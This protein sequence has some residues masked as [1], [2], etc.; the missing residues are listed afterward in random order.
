LRIVVSFS[1]IAPIRSCH[2]ISMQ[3]ECSSK[4]SG[5]YCI[6]LSSLVFFGPRQGHPDVLR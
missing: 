2:T 3:L 6:C 1:V 5:L 4:N